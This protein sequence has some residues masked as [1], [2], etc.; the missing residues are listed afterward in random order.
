VFRH[1]VKPVVR[2]RSGLSLALILLSACAA[3][4]QKNPDVQVR[5]SLANDKDFYRGGEPI[6]LELTFT[7]R[8][9]GY[10]MNDVTTELASP[11]DQVLLSP[12][13]GVYPW[14]D[15][16][17]RERRY[18]PDY[19]TSNELQ[20]G[21][22]FTIELP[23]NALYRFD[24]PGRYT[25]H[26]VTSRVASGDLLHPKPV[27]ALTSNDVSFDTVP[28]DDT[29]EAARAKHLE[30]LIRSAPDLRTAQRYASQLQW[31]T[32]DPST[33]VKLS[34]FLHPKE[35]YPF[36]VDVSYG[37]WVA[38]NRAFVVSIL[39]QAM[40][41]PQQPIGPVASVLQ[42][43]VAL[44]SRLESPYDPASPIA[45]PQA[46]QIED[47]YVRRIVATLPQREDANLA[48]TAI[49]LLISLVQRDKT[50][51]PEFEAAREAIITHFADVNEYQVDWVLNGYG[52][53][54]EDT[55]MIPALE[56]M[57]KLI[58]F[59]TTRAAIENQLAALRAKN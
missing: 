18:F 7:A 21:Q 10:Q 13:K 33:Q 54:L 16:Y 42:M 46:N 31:L 9:L 32:G 27:G 30:S 25:V 6:V 49:T 4:A 55:R 12:A 22:P 24:E 8:V 23:L 59:D 29:D 2:M 35:F 36:G 1:G 15:D 45:L 44:K 28:M 34:L 51:T 50:D 43:A 19:E 47:G 20:P 40:S 37:L 56:N 57:L 5:L 17:S 38:R 14:L 26:V 58:K 52:K 48:S 11:V 3:L 53:Y 41:D 39:E